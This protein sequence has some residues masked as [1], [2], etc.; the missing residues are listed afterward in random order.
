[1][2]TAEGWVTYPEHGEYVTDV[3]G[4]SERCVSQVHKKHNTELL[5]LFTAG[6]REWS[7]R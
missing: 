7:R 2:Y 1:M 5:T 6:K 3:A 4:G